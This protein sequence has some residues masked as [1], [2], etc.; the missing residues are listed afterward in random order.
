MQQLIIEHSNPSYQ[1]QAI[2]YLLESYITEC[3]QVLKNS[4]NSNPSQTDFSPCT[5]CECWDQVNCTFPICF[6]FHVFPL[7]F[8]SLSL[9][10]VPALSLPG[11]YITKSLALISFRTFSDFYILTVQAHKE[12]LY[13]P[14]P[15]FRC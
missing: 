2:T 5:I 11:Q 15:L 6:L 12:K 8:L 7:S 10:T 14:D 4:H 9:S 3:P 13:I 1:W